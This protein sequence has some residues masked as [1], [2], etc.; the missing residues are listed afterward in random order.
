MFEEEGWD[1]RTAVAGDADAIRA[2]VRDVYAKYVPRMGRESKP[3]TADY[4]DAIAA[5]QVW[6]LAAGDRLVATLELIAEP[7]AFVLENIAVAA[8][9]QGRGVGARLLDFAEAQARRQGYDAIL[10]YTN[11][12][13]FENVALYTRRGY[14]ETHRETVE[15]S[16]AVH[17]RKPL[18]GS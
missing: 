7:E 16:D 10:L 4:S 6:G 5:H 9:A 15:G 17:M 14:V 8:A 12:H 1:F 11:E 18:A 13:M 2:L 3:M